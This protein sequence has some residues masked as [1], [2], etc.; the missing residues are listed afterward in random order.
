MKIPGYDPTRHLENYLLGI[1]GAET[2]GAQNSKTTSPSSTPR[3]RVDL[4]KQANE[5]RKLNDLVASTPD[6]RTDRVS[7]VQQALD[8]GTYNSRAERVAGNMVRAAVID[9]IL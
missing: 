9:A 2:A 5:Y 6:V 4:S 8:A 1:K 3:D 7:E